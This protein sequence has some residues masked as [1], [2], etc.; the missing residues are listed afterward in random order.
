MSVTP[1]G[2]TKVDIGTHAAPTGSPPIPEPEYHVTLVDSPLPPV[3]LFRQIWQGLHEPKFIVPKKYYGKNVAGD[4]TPTGAEYHLTFVD[5]TLPPVSLFRQIWQGLH[6]PKVPKEYYRKNATADATSTGSSPIDGPEYHFTFVDST[7][8]PVSLFRQIWQGLHEPKVPKE[9]Y[10]RKTSAG[11]LPTE[12]SAVPGAEFHPTFV[13]SALP[14][15]SLFRQVFEMVREPK[16]TGK[17]GYDR[18]KATPLATDVP[19]VFVDPNQ[20]NLFEKP[21]ALPTPIGSKPTDLPQDWQD[22]VLL[23]LDPEAIKWRRR[24]M[25]LSSVI[26]HG[27]LVL[28]LVFSPDLLRRG[29]Q[30]MGLPVEVAPKKE[31]SY[32]FIPPDVLR[33]LREPPPENAPLS[34]KNR[35][36]QGRSPI[37]NPNGLHMPYSLGNTKLPELAGGNPPAAAPTPPPGW[38]HHSAPWQSAVEPDSCGT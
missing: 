35:R 6:E 32:L 34:D 3:S 12:S 18:R 15:V 21:G 7:L 8:P 13:D 11:V 36:A 24:T 37:I 29:R 1:T 23:D 9:Y 16:V 31:F 30:M 2:D 14:P 19:P 28:I 22:Y 17:R 10:Q 5:S 4:A 25:Y 27:I 20:L 26:F 38:R 33:R